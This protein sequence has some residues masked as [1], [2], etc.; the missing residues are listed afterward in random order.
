MAGLLYLV[1][2][3]PDLRRLLT[4]V[5]GDAGWQVVECADGSE[6]RDRLARGGGAAL[7]LLDL[8]M[9]KM[10]GIALLRSFSAGDPRLALVFITGGA[11][12]NA[13][14][15]R[16][17]AEGQGLRVLD[18]LFKPFP[19]ERFRAVLARAAADG[20]GRA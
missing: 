2:D 5:A 7:V 15:A 3:D 19:L 17:I 12:V 4:A 11:E 6:L 20:I 13:T 16:F 10:D 18:T 8:N 9:P 14:A 1:D